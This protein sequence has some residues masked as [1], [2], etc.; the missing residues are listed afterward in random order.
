MSLIIEVEPDVY[1]A[2]SK[3][4]GQTVVQQLADA[5]T[6]LKH[7]LADTVGMAGTDPGGAGWANAYD[8]AA[9]ATA[10]AMTDLTYAC[11]RLA[12]MLE[13]TGFNHGMAEA[14]SDPSR[15]VPTPPDTTRYEGPPP[16]P[17][18]EPD[19]PSAHGG[20]GHPPKGWGL[21][22][23][24]VGYVWPN[25]NPGKLRAG[26]KAWATAAGKLNGASYSIPE[27]LHAIRSQQS[28]EVEDAATVCQAMMDHI[29]DVATSCR[30]LSAACSDL[31]EYIDKAHDEVKD[32]LVSLIEW[33]VAIE[34]SGAIIGAFTLGIGEGA[35][36][37]AEAGRI[38][39][40]AA[41]VG[42]IIARFITFAGTVTAR[43][44][45]AVSKI[46]EV[47]QRLKPLL[48]APLVRTTAK[49]TKA[50]AEAA[51]AEKIAAQAR[52]VTEAIG[53]PKKFNPDLIKGMSS[54]GLEDSIP[55]NWTREA[56]NSGGGTVFRDPN[57]A[58][59]QIRV[60]PG[61]IEGNRPDLVTHGP[62]AVVSQNG[63][64]VK[65]PLEGNPTLGGK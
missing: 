60:M 21:I 57:N 11:Y 1:S 59:R 37:A 52:T 17:R 35:A 2:A 56:S 61:Y 46:A 18:C 23:H 34:A 50:L 26:A 47:A 39:A 42:T 49:E 45:A 13:V 4:F 29:N 43:I 22:E 65:I 5:V 33:T 44:G 3:V 16:F 6:G 38:A 14:A 54:K 7:S 9:A 48:R 63:R 64:T 31:A 19:P 36:Q 10:D 32:E 62:Y 20:S 25:G 55:S 53:D 8:P 40:T 41:R 27:A 28:P 58:G 24:T 51:K 12:A 15:T 30:E